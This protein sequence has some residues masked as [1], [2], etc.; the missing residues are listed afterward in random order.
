MANYLLTPPTVDE[1]F[2]QYDRMTDPLWRFYRMQVAQS[3]VKID[4]TW[5]VVRLDSYPGEEGLDVVYRGGSTHVVDQATADDITADG[6]GSLLS[7]YTGDAYADA[8]LMDDPFI[9]YRLGESDAVALDSSGGDRDGSLEPNPVA[10]L[11][12]S[13]DLATQAL[14]SEFGDV[15]FGYT[16]VA[17]F[18]TGL[19]DWSLEAW[20]RSDGGTVVISVLHSDVLCTTA[21]ITNTPAPG[22]LSFL[23][24][25]AEDP[26][27]ANYATLASSNWDDGQ[28]HHVVG[29]Y[30]GSDMVLYLD[31]EAVATETVTG[32]LD[33]DVM[34][35][36]QATQGNTIFDEVAF[37]TTALSPTRVQA[38]YE[39]GVA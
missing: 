21:I 1:S 19:T 27:T 11:V 13:D 15:V 10:G 9:Y 34:A 7:L 14:G 30:D 3:V 8:V 38:H 37:Y 20:L 31:G 22:D 16:P 32:T 36:Q 24:R 23:V 35:G 29:A 33:A 6:L 18:A 17:D 4:G 12:T 5:Q 25:T 39:A 26:L 28:T 2:T